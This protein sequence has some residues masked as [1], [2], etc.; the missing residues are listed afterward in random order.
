MMNGPLNERGRMSR[1]LAEEK[2]FGASYTVESA[3]MYIA[4]MHSEL[5]EMLEA[6]RAGSPR[7]EK[8]ATSLEAEEAADL[9]IRLTHYCSVRGIDLDEAVALKHE[10]NKGRPFKHGKKF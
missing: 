9:L 2:G 5:S 1:A 8:I 3:A 4:L 7:S 10:Y 6:V